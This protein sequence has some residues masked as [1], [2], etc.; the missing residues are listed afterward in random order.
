MPRLPAGQPQ[1]PNDSLTALRR[2]RIGD[3]FGAVPEI[4]EVARYADGSSQAVRGQERDI[5]GT[6]TPAAKKPRRPV[7]IFGTRLGNIAL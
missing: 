2:N 4:G 7:G 6:R 1:R 5:L 3:R